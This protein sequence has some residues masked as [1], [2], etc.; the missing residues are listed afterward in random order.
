M[1][2]RRDNLI[3]KTFGRLTVVSFCDKDKYGACRWN[4]LCICGGTTISRSYSLKTGRTK[5]CGCLQKEAVVNKLTTHGH[6]HFEKNTPEYRAWIAMKSRCYNK[7][8]RSYPGYGGRGIVVCDEWLNDF[9]AFYSHIGKRPS[10]D[11][12]LDRYPNND[13][14]YEPGNVRWATDEEQILNR[15]CNVWL[16]YKGEKMVVAEFKRRLG[17]KSQQVL[18]Y[19]KTQTPEQ[20]AHYYINKKSKNG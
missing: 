20:V 14:H 11:H 5:S 4:C 9:P 15:N 6:S 16:V 2:L 8:L 10:P 17:I 3:G 12:S 1:A 13:G 7:N 18:K 19:L